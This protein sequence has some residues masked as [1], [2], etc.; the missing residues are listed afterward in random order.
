MTDFDPI[1]AMQEEIAGL[2]DV[3]RVISM[4][5][6]EAEQKLAEAE[7]DHDSLAKLSAFTLGMLDTARG[8]LKMLQDE[9]ERIKTLQDASDRKDNTT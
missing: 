4:R 6:R 7:I 1:K 5:A 9:I 8:K 2:T 3:H